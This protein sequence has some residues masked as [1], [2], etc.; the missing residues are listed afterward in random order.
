MKSEFQ[1][2]PV[3]HCTAPFKLLSIPVAPS[4]TS[5]R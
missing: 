4:Q 5:P 1:L 2:I 3:L